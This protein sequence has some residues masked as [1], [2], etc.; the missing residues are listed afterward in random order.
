MSFAFVTAA[1][2]GSIAPATRNRAMSA[3]QM[4]FETF[5][6]LN[7]SDYRFHPKILRID[8]GLDQNDISLF[9]PLYHLMQ[10]MISAKVNLVVEVKLR[11]KHFEGSEMTRMY[12]LKT[13]YAAASAGQKD[14]SYKY[15][16][17]AL[18]EINLKGVL[19]NRFEQNLGCWSQV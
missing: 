17:N 1:G 19:D 10:R 18:V 15:V 13:E 6:V 12:M 5:Y 7:Y 8:H 14:A 16:E 9:A 2:K 3:L 4:F 11:T